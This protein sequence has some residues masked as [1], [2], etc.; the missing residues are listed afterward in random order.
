MRHASRLVLLL[1]LL[2]APATARA[3]DARTP[4]SVGARSFTIAEITAAGRIDADGAM[5]DADLRAAGA[6][7]LARAEWHAQEAAARGLTADPALID[8]AIAEDLRATGGVDG[9]ARYLAAMHMTAEQRRAEIADGLLAEAITDD[10]LRTTAPGPVAFGR[11]FDALAQRQRA[12]TACVRAVVGDLG[13]LCGNVTPADGRCTAMAAEDL[14]PIRSDG[15]R[16]WYVGGDLIAAFVDPRHSDE[17]DADTLLGGLSRLRR[18][19]VAHGSDALS[20]C[21]DDAD[22]LAYIDCPRRADAIAVTWAIARIHVA[23]K[24]RWTV[25]ATSGVVL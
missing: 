3:V 2:A 17:A 18:F 12:A 4:L 14:C 5:R 20:R 9:R 6:Q 19:L 7:R 16:L 8:A 13:G 25:P 1:L 21:E 15:R 23:A 24:R 10:V 22:D 11:A